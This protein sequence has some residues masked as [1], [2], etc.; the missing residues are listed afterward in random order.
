MTSRSIDAT[1]LSFPHTKTPPCF[2]DPRNATICLHCGQN[3]V[4]GEDTE[5]QHVL[6]YDPIF[7][8]ATATNQVQSSLHRSIRSGPPHGLS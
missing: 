7:R 3:A 5:Y 8:S 4:Q 6:E 1:R 2:I